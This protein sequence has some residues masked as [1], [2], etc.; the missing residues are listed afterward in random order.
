MQG[1]LTVEKI[2]HTEPA[3]EEEKQNIPLFFR[4]TAPA[5]DPHGK[6][7]AHPAPLYISFSS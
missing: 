2:D 6:L 3:V 7:S 4:D 5:Y 1:V